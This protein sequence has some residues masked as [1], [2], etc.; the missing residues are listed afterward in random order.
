MC[1]PKV[2]AAPPPPVVQP[3]PILEQT[4]PDVNKPAEDPQKDA[5]GTKRYRTNSNLSIAKRS[6]GKAGIKIR[7]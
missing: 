3:T 6:G 5:R 4:A 7:K 1:K 2:P